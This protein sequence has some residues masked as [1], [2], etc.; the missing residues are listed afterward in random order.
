M[1]DPVDNELIQLAKVLSQQLSLP[2]PACIVQLWVYRVQYQWRPC[3]CIYYFSSIKL[4][5]KIFIKLCSFPNGNE[6]Y[7]YPPTL[8]AV[9]S[10]CVKN[11]LNSKKR[12]QMRQHFGHQYMN[13]LSMSLRLAYCTAPL[14]LFVKYFFF[15][16]IFSFDHS[17]RWESHSS[18]ELLMKRLGK[19]SI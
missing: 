15:L 11:R 16:Q 1:S 5:F 4:L 17:V 2:N 14:S 7:T 10:G 6:P 3:N 8:T 9:L 13:Y 19:K 18:H 12:R